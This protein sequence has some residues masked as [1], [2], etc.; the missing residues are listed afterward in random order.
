MINTMTVINGIL[1]T[2]I[3]CITIFLVVEKIITMVNISL[4]VNPITMD[5]M[6][7]IE[8]RDKIIDQEPQVRVAGL[9]ALGSICCVLEGIRSS[10][11]LSKKRDNEA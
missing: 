7:T 5:V 10:I 1:V 4:M 3:V 6:D 9:R 11:C 8:N 2:I